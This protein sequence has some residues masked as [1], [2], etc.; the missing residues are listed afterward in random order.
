MLFSFL[1]LFSLSLALI[2]S[3]GPMQVDDEPAAPPPPKK[4]SPKQPSGK[5]CKVLEFS[6]FG[7]DSKP[8]PY[9][10]KIFSF[11]SLL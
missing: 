2:F 1:S 11:L 8:A 7:K 3:Q 6:W 4:D 10:P 5:P 9:E